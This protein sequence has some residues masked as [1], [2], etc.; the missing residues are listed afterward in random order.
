MGGHVVFSTIRRH[1]SANANPSRML[2]NLERAGIV[3]RVYEQGFGRDGCHHDIP[4]VNALS[5]RFH[6]CQALADYFTLEE[7]RR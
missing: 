3:A 2:R 7:I 1:G 6:P 5:D 4:V